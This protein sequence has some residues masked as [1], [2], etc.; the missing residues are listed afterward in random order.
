MN[1]AI[2]D[3]ARIKLA[4]IFT[5]AAKKEM[6]NLF[7]TTII[8]PAL[9]NIGKAGLKGAMLGGLAGLGKT[10]LTSNDTTPASYGDYIQNALVGAGLGGLAGTGLRLYKELPEVIKTHK[11][12][13]NIYENSMPKYV[14]DAF[15]YD[16]NG[17]KYSNAGR[18]QSSLLN[19]LLVNSPSKRNPGLEKKLK[20][21]EHD[22]HQFYYNH[23][24]KFVQHEIIPQNFKDKISDYFML[25]YLS[26]SSNP[27][28]R[29]FSKKFEKNM[30]VSNFKNELDNLI[31]AESNKELEH[32]FMTL[33]RNLPRLPYNS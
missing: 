8:K 12:F 20:S 23:Y 31:R 7:K 13:K 9:N 29:N 11:T 2:L 5:D 4:S 26:K 1:N 21:I 27:V 18:V 28:F 10:Y 3:K 19:K 22:L 33:L 14:S 25:D 6:D 32:E 16:Y 24:P 30:D 17:Y 15:N